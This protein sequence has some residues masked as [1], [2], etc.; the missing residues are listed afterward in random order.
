MKVHYLR[1]VV[2]RL[3]VTVCIGTPV[4]AGT[5]S[6][7]GF[8]EQLKRTH[9]LFEKEQLTSE[10]QRQKRDSYLG[11]QDWNVQSSLFYT[12]DE[13]SFVVAGP[14]KTDAISFTGGLERA[15]WS[16]GG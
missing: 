2:L 10:I 14:E 16:T 15:I 3:V 9:P 11:N 4:I 5:I 7:D 8:L 6:Q 12:H 13:P 1:I